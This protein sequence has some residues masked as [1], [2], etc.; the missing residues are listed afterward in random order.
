MCLHAKVHFGPKVSVTRRILYGW[1]T[2]CRRLVLRNGDT[3]AARGAPKRLSPRK[4]AKIDLLNIKKEG[5]FCA[6]L[7]TCFPLAFFRD[8]EKFCGLSISEAPSGGVRRSNGHARVSIQAKNLKILIVKVRSQTFPSAAAADRRRNIA[9]HGVGAEHAPD[10][11]IPR[12]HSTFMTT[13]CTSSS[14]WTPGSHATRQLEWM[15]GRQDCADLAW[16]RRHPS[17]E[18]CSLG[19][20]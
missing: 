20:V 5:K 13:G 19:G 6:F 2:F 8:F 14:P 10:L 15:P 16:G 11:G 3:A 18:E 4:S 1:S 7:A 17:W 12:A 9:K